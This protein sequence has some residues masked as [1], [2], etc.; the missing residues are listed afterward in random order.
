MSDKHKGARSHYPP[1]ER[2]GPKLKSG[3]VKTVRG[4][5]SGGTS[6]ARGARNVGGAMNGRCWQQ[7]I[8]EQSKRQVRRSE[9][10][11]DFSMLFLKDSFGLLLSSQICRVQ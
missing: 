5:N 1:V 10:F 2:N 9:R 6:N 4:K 8:K 7:R 3:H 11:K